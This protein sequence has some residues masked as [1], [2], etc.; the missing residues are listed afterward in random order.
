LTKI[1]QHISLKIIGHFLANYFFSSY[2][3]ASMALDVRKTETSKNN[4]T[5]FFKIL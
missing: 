5:V 3:A 4:K 2:F 1:L